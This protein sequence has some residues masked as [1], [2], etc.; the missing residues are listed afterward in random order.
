[1]VT[2]AVVGGVLGHQIGHGSGN[3]VAT[4]GG[5][6]LGAFLGSRIG[7]STDREDQR[8]AAHAHEVAPD[9][10]STAWRN[11]NTGQI[12]SVTPTRTYGSVSSPCRDFTTTTELEGE[13]V[14]HGT[15]CRQSDGS[16]KTSS[17]PMPRDP[18]RGVPLGVE[19]A[20]C[21]AAPAEEGPRSRL[22]RFIRARKGSTPRAAEPLGWAAAAPDDSDFQA[23]SH[24]DFIGAL[25]ASR[26]PGNA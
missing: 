23:F 16:W 8:K 14:V 9:N 22:R 5:A 24:G 10:R 26:P 21:P 6:A 7:R 1:M 2:G 20:W 15:A 17:G 19:C 11:P 13:E 12:Y 25:A 3:T 18:Y 4:I